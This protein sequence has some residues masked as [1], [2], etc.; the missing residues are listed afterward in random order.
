MEL[1]A[2]TA[3][4]SKALSFQAAASISNTFKIQIRI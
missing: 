3:E 4:C 2:M 1:A